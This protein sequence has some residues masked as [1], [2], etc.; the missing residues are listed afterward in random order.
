MSDAP[1]G[2]ELPDSDKPPVAARR[3]RR[4]RKPSRRPRWLR[5]LIRACVALLAIIVA[6]AGAE[7]AYVAFR[8]HEVHRVTL[9]HLS[10]VATSGPNV[11]EQTFLLI[12]STSRCALNGK[13]SQA[14]GSCAQG[15]TG[16]NADVILLLRADQKTHSISILS[17]PRD[18]A[19]NN[20]RPGQFYKIDAALADGPDQL[21]AAIEQ[22]FGIP[23]NHFV[24][25]NFD[26]FQSIVSALGGIKMYF[27]YRVYDDS[28][29]LHIR[30]TGCVYLDGFNSLAL[31]RARNYWYFKNGQWVEDGS[32]DLGRIVRVH[33]FL[34]VLATA[35]AKQGLGNIV[36]DNDLLGAVAPDLE[37]DSKLSL[38]DM[39]DLLRAFHGT[40]ISAVPELTMPNVENYADYIYDGHD[41]GSVV[42]PTYPQD[43]Q[44]VDKFLGLKKP[45]ASRLAPG[46][47]TVSVLNGTGTA[48][49]ATT[50]AGDL[51]LLG[52]HVVG[53]DASTPVGPI[54]ETV[55]YYKPGDLLDA[56]RVVED[57]HG[58]VA[59]AQGPTDAGADVTVVTG[60]EYVVLAAPRHSAVTTTTTGTKTS[61]GKKSS[62][63]KKTSSSSSTTSTTAATTTT[64]S[65]TLPPPA[66]TLGSP[67]PAVQPLPSYDPRACPAA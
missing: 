43:Q 66:P 27:P 37:I 47:V 42:L 19:M 9:H 13:Q 31:V 53:T 39:V 44:A 64:T 36:T 59:M 52:F 20:V 15:I 55:A 2:D 10:K 4:V 54:S 29:G 14:F 63:G 7:V 51:S 24:E 22:N 61:T 57:I 40:D 41:Y 3:R 23:I 45:P 33:E 58:L 18:L 6:L 1:S 25:L 17:I 67:S 28:S 16:V 32:G 49:Q 26:S 8:Y 65:T 38:S 50:T 30:T 48:G 11:G 56:E 34:R 60:S 21:V 5:N 35:V 12:G 46:K 62:T